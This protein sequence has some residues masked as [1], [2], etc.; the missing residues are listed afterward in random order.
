MIQ[1]RCLGE[2]WNKNFRKSENEF[3]KLV[4]EP[5]PFVTRDPRSPR[6]YISTEKRVS[7]N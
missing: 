5:G 3:M 6:R 7:A 1:N 4:D 2:D